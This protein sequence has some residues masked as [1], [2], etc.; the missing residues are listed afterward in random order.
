MDILEYSLAGRAANGSCIHDYIA[1]L[2]T[3]EPDYAVA[4]I[5]CGT[6]LA[7][8]TEG[9]YG[10]ELIIIYVS[11]PNVTNST[12]R[13]SFYGV[14]HGESLCPIYSIQGITVFDA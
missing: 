7:G 12:F 13:A 3:T 6:D 4:G 10:N 14:N 5:S 2:E 1:F 11:D 9:S 8:E